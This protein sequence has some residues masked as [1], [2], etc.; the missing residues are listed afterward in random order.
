MCDFIESGQHSACN[1]LPV[2]LWAHLQIEPNGFQIIQLPF[3]DDLRAPEGEPILAGAPQ[4][5]VPPAAVDAATGLIESLN[6]DFVVGEWSNP[7]LQRY[8]QVLPRILLHVSLQTLQYALHGLVE[9]ASSKHI[10]E[11]YDAISMS[12]ANSSLAAGQSFVVARWP[13]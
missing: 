8:Y 6:L 10:A 1:T 11:S 12:M 13:R 7:V 9:L 5:P 3:S 4:T 2:Q